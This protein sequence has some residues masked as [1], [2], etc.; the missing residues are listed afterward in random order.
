MHY[1]E[2]SVV[3]ADSWT[4]C[5]ANISSISTTCAP[6]SVFHDYAQRDPLQEYKSEAFELFTS[7][8]NN[9]RQ[10]VTAQM[11]R[12]ELAVQQE[13][14][15]PPVMQAHHIDPNTGEDEFGSIYRHRT[16]PSHPKTATP[17]T[18]HLGQGW[19]QQVCPCGS[20]RSTSTATVPSNR[21]KP[22]QA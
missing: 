17:A 7:L 14:P 9:L 10:A 2:R 6:S 22:V 13:Q 1:V 11:M 5:G 8:L 19:P 12:V 18:R 4:R 20:G 21:P 15:Q 3:N 16:S